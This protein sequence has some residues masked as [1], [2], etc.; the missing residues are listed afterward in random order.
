[1]TKQELLDD[2]AGRSFVKKI[3][4]PQLIEEKPDGSKWY[5]VNVAEAYQNVANFR[6]VDFY[7][8]DENTEEEAAYYR[9][10]DPRLGVSPNQLK[11][12]IRK[13][14]E[15]LN[16]VAA[17]NFRRAEEYFGKAVVEVLL[18]SEEEGKVIPALYLLDRLEDGTFT[19]KHI[20]ISS[21][22]VMKTSDI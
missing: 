2:L 16:D 7:V 17:W 15:T 21:E 10:T 5:T 22:I 1:M 4:N 8:F 6:N 3:A 11:D 13:Y 9:N 20:D 18:Y 19:H 14:L 12:G